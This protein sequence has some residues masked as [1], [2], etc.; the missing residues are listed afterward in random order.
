MSDTHETN[1]PITFAVAFNGETKMA[2]AIPEKYGNVM[3][4]PF[5]EDNFFLGLPQKMGPGLYKGTMDFDFYEGYSE[6]YPAPGESDWRFT[7]TKYEKVG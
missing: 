5:L 4:G 3:D 7:V 6:G 1:L 2:V